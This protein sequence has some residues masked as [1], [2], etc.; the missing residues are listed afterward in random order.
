MKK[1]CFITTNLLPVPAVKGGAIEGIMTNI[2]KEQEKHNAFEMTMVSLYDKKAY[3][4]SQNYK[5]TKFIYIK[6]NIYYKLYA[7]IYNILN[8]VF[9]TNFNTYNHI[10]LKKIRKEKFD[11]IVAEGGNYES[12]REFLKYFSKDQLVLHLHHQATPTKKMDNTFSKLIGVSQFVIDDYKKKS[13]LK[14]YYLLKNC[15]DIKTFDKE[16]NNNEIYQLRKKY[17]LKKADFVVIFCGRLIKE[18][19]VLELIKAVKKCDNSNIKLLVVGS[20][21]FANGGISD[22]T[23]KLNQEILGFEDRIKLTGFIDNDEL[24]KY[25]KMSDVMAIPSIC[26]EA[27]GLVCIEG[28]VCK[29][30]IITT[31]SG[32]IKEYV[33]ENAIL[34]NRDETLVDSLAKAIEKTA[35][36][37]SDQ[38]IGEKAYKDALK[39]S[40]EKYYECLTDIINN[41]LK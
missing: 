26:E 23:E 15:I 14:E 35:K 36:N 6:K 9:K 17:G 5:K 32:G 18:K 20:I 8:K 3:K 31:G 29:K 4:D 25:I 22:Y 21:N 27:A 10:V 34:I 1:V 39:F 24:Y 2:I 40:S 7:V 16:M 11:Y 13:S 38:K 19:G 30:Q 37:K 28:M 12:Y 41:K 33:N